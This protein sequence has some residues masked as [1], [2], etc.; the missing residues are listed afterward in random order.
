MLPLDVLDE[1]NGLIIAGCQPDDTVHLRAELPVPP[2]KRQK[3]AGATKAATA[4]QL[5]VL[6][7]L[8]SSPGLWMAPLC[9]RQLSPADRRVWNQ[10][11]AMLIGLKIRNGFGEKELTAAVGTALHVFH[12]GAAKHNCEDCGRVKVAGGASNDKLRGASI[13]L[14]GP[15]DLTI[16]NRAWPPIH[17]E[18]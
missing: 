4:G 13:G 17:I 18:A 7:W 9:G 8:D 2:S 6:K 11:I 3:P 5:D 14:H 1:T 16:S 10:T 12:D 15:L